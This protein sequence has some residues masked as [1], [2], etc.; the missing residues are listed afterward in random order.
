MARLYGSL[1]NNKKTIGN[2]MGEK[3]LAAHVRTWGAGVYVELKVNDQDETI[4][5]VF[6]T[7]GSDSPTTRELLYMRNLGV[8]SK[9]RPGHGSATGGIGNRVEV[10]E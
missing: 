9:R 2:K 8:T 7:S 3:F 1:D 10:R 5:R 4:V 6:S